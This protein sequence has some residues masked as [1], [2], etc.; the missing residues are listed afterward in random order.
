M[1]CYLHRGEQLVAGSGDEG[2][3][4]LEDNIL[5]KM[6]I[7]GLGSF[8]FAPLSYAIC[9]VVNSSTPSLFLAYL[10]QAAAGAWSQRRILVTDDRYHAAIAKLH[11][12]YHQVPVLKFKLPVQHWV[13]AYVFGLLEY[14][15]P[16][17]DGGHAGASATILDAEAKK[18]FEHWYRIGKHP[19]EL[20]FILTTLF[21]S[22]MVI[23][24]FCFCA[25][26][27]DVPQLSEAE[28]HESYPPDY[29]NRRLRYWAKLSQAAEAS[30][31]GSLA[32][33]ANEFAK[34]QWQYVEGSSQQSERGGMALAKFLTKLVLAYP[35]S[36]RVLAIVTMVVSILSSVASMSMASYDVYEYSKAVNKTLRVLTAFGALYI[37]MT[38]VRLSAAFVCPTH[39]FS[40]LCVQCVAW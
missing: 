39:N 31:L 34:A 17:T 15:D 22:S 1:T 10:V 20:E 12:A 7:F 18:A 32:G 36:A 8:A 5:A 4:R 33:T 16:T 26:T 24:L 27:R 6:T 23:Q 11:Q 40:I 2:Y 13:V 30:S 29:E 25:F 14:V 28:R 3:F 35:G 37:L 19:L 38:L 21:I 9:R